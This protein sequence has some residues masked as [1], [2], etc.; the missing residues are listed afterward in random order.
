MTGLAAPEE[1]KEISMP[2]HERLGPHNRQELTPSD[3]L[4]EQGECEREASSVRRGRTWRS[5]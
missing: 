2:P 1:A 3:Q 5:M 4:R